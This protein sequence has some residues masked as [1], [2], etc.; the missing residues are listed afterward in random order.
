[1]NSDGT[2]DQTF[3]NGGTG[4][5]GDIFSIVLQSDGKILVGGNF[6]SYNDN[7]GTYSMI[8]ICRLNSDG[9][10]DTT[11]NSGATG[12]DF[13]VASIAIQSDGKI[14]CTGGFTEYTDV[15]NTYFMDSICR[16]NSDGTFDTTFNNGGSGLNNVG[17]SLSIQ[18]DGK[19]LCGGEFGTYT[20]S[21]TT[22]NMNSICRLNTD[23]TFDTTFNNGGQGFN[24]AV[25]SIV[26]QSDGKILCGGQF[27]SYD[28]NTGSNFKNKI[29]RLNTD[30]SF[31]LSF[32]QGSIG[33]SG[34]N[35][36]Y[37][38][39][40]VQEPIFNNIS[41]DAIYKGHSF[42]PFIYPL[43]LT[44]IFFDVPT[45]YLYDGTNLIP[46]DNST[47][48]IFEFVGT[49]ITNKKLCLIVY[50]KKLDSYDLFV[51]DIILAQPRD[52]IGNTENNVT[53]LMIN[54]L[55]SI[56]IT[57]LGSNIKSRQIKPNNL[58]VYLGILDVT[59]NK[60]NTIP[61]YKIIVDN[62]GENQIFRLVKG[63]LNMN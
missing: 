30:G 59:T 25:F 11:F 4:T 23:G 42:R 24:D 8:G 41:V 13:Y 43:N 51:E 47:N 58:E 55:E 20:D 27:V 45:S 50:Y 35:T 15:N 57:N 37:Q 21:A 54:N 62:Y 48:N 40:L 10:F 1:L 56:F 18:S 22:H 14:I 9:T 63:G 60:V 7:T 34:T 33:F 5:L 49:T 6:S 19:I 3:N 36:V 26:I 2:F 28:D 46:S 52:L 32:N 12:F 44:Q 17:R 16:L 38:I 39:F 31:D 53:T 61:N 29:C